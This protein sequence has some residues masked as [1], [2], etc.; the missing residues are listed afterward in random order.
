MPSRGSPFTGI[1]Q[2]RGRQKKRSVFLGSTPM[3]QRWAV[4][5]MSSIVILSAA[6][7]PAVRPH[8]I[9]LPWE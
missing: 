2:L 7:D 8:W 6:D 1:L 9:L 3:P 4:L 5:E